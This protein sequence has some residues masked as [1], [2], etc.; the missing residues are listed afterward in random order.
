[1]TII[2]A[3]GLGTRLK[4]GELTIVTEILGAGSVGQPSQT[5]SRALRYGLIANQRAEGGTSGDEIKWTSDLNQFKFHESK[6]NIQT[7]MLSKQMDQ[8]KRKFSRTSLGVNQVRFI[9][10]RVTRKTQR[11][12]NQA[13]GL[14]KAKLR[15]C[16]GNAWRLGIK[17]EP[18]SSHTK[19]TIQ[20]L[21]PKRTKN[22]FT[23]RRRLGEL[24]Q[25]IM[26]ATQALDNQ[27][28]WWN[29]LGGP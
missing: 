28:I 20:R 19:L 15:G 27:E 9:L 16:L 17:S 3:V 26:P 24:G 2:P 29:G 14:V 1:V 22:Q 13:R 7:R 8:S 18:D 6:T 21:H 12:H 11:G 5:P 4:A 10:K 25:E 23:Y